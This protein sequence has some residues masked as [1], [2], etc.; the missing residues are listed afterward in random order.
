[1][2]AIVL[3]GGGSK[4][5]YQIGVWKALR[6]LRI[7]YDIVTG[8]SVGA[9]NGALMTQGNFHRAL[10]VWKSI[11]LK[12]LFGEDAEESENTIEVFKMYK[13]NFIKNGGMEV[14]DLEKL[15]DENI[16]KK[17]FY[18]SKVNFGL[19]TMNLDTIKPLIVK[20]NDIAKEKLT[21]YLVA[22]ASCF[23]VFQKKEINNQNYIDGGYYDNLPINL[24]IELGADEIIAVDLKAPGIKRKP[25]KKIPTI[26]IKPN[27]KLTNFLN[28]YEEGTKKNI[29]YGYNDTMKAFGKLEGNNY[30]FKK[31]TIKKN[32]KKYSETWKYLIDKTIDK[33]LLTSLIK[34]I[35]K[36]DSKKE[37]KEIGIVLLKIME[38]LGKEFNI[39]D[40]KIYSKRKFNKLIKKNFKT[41]VKYYE[42]KNEED[43]IIEIYKNMKNKNKKKLK[44]DILLSSKEFFKALYLYTIE[45]D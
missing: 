24:A 16:N 28:F 40:T 38:D 15:I 5:S 30:T 11:N 41:K 9:L 25:T 4:G 36:I 43:K 33:N 42:M 37:N 22:S 1:M 14:K 29:K 7:K 34:K 45:E 27:N 23:P 3:S 21:D 10:K 2:K 39:D 18:S 13:D 35:Y 6:K 44:K 20:K 31:N 17:K 8:T 32:I 12:T 26:T 19:I